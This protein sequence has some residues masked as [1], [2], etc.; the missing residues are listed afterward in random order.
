MTPPIKA[1][2]IDPTFGASGD[3]FLGALSD[4]VAAVTAE[5]VSAVVQTLRNELSSLEMTGYHLE[6]SP[7]LRNGI[8][9]NRLEVILTSDDLQPKRTWAGIDAM[10]S[11]SRLPAR[12]IAG[13]RAT[14]LR[15]GQV[16]ADQ[17][18]VKLD[19]VH[20][21]EV[22]AI[23]SIVDIVGSWLLFDR[24][25]VEEVVVGPVGLGHGVVH[26]AHGKLPLPAPATAALLV[27][28]PIHSIDSAT[29]T[30]T[31]TGA[32]LLAEFADRA[33][34]IPAGT[35]VAI[36]RGAGGR[37]PSTHPNVLS[38][39]LVEPSLVEP[40]LVE[41]SLV[42][43]SL[44]E[45]QSAT[46][47]RSRNQPTVEIAA[48]LRT[49]I[50]DATPEVLARTVQL[51]LDAGADDVWQV[52][53]VMKKGRSATELAVLCSPELVAELASLVFEQTGT[54]GLR[55]SEVSKHVLPRNQIDSTVRGHAI[56]IKLGPYGAKPEYDDLVRISQE[57]GVPIRTLS[58]EIRL[59]KALSVEP[60]LLPPSVPTE[61]KKRN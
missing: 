28:L 44:V 24:L 58:Q 7:Q 59:K 38:L 60:G 14:F 61:P 15:L 33:G 51:L 49:N 31:P 41:P 37:D 39:L 21:H 13:A 45:P 57:T 2:W 52:P 32:A 40:S 1:L 25:G 19:E 5:P 29:E 26:A 4:L 17:H 27:G 20:F 46:E 10:L 6:Q 12:V 53:I 30:C 36:V 23:D 47:T 55:H 3:M 50:D 9:A 54:L 18:G 56:S 48:L 35:M 42:E 11:Q 16:E 43:P 22:G 8:Q 34:P